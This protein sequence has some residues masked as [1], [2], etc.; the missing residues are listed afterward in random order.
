MTSTFLAPPTADSA[1]LHE[2]F[3][4]VFERIAKDSA[5]RENGRTLVH[6]QVRWL[7]DAGFGTLRIP[8]DR[9][10]LGA[11]LQQTFEL[12][13]DLGAADPNVAHVFRNHLAFVED[14]LA[15]A[16]TPA[17]EAWIARF[18]AGEFVGGGWTEANNGTLDNLKTVITPDGDHW[19]VTGAKFYATGS[20][21]AD[22]LDVLG[23][24][25]DDGPLTALVRVDQP[26]VQ[27]VDDWVGFGQRVTG[28]GSATYD[29]A[30][31]ETDNVIPYA[32]R[33]P[34][35][36][37]FYQEAM[38]AALAGIAAAAHRDGIEALKARKRTYRHAVT[39]SITDDPQLLQV[40]GRVG[41][42][43]YGARSALS[44][45]AATLDAIVSSRLTNDADAVQRQLVASN[46]A[47]SQAQI[48]I[49]EHT[50]EAATIVFDALGASGVSEKLRLDRHW[51]NARTLASHNPRVYKERLLGDWF[52]NGRNPL[53]ALTG[54]S[55]HDAS[56]A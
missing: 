43:A 18:L 1:R 51:R 16:V 37:H 14:R 52:V 56:Q 46:V 30:R 34:Y 3:A 41:A 40:I 5:D 48:V 53:Q 31:I 50:L 27:V 9:G 15:A 49:I 29:H 10:G 45:S 36:G 12:L 20:L 13:T 17:N 55:S 32:D 23:K 33:A 42:L 2:A 19:Q 22:W 21:Y 35:L 26:G 11:S 6:E 54:A 7:V 24:G 38:L 44:A 39:G 25:P 8:V 28:S 4:P 47:I